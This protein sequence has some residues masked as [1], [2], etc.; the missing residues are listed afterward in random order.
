V[1]RRL[2]LNL[3]LRYDYQRVRESAT[4]RIS[5]LIRTRGIPRTACWE[6]WNSPESISAIRRCSGPQRFCSPR[7][8]RL[9][10][11]RNAERP[12]AAG[13]ASILDD[14]PVIYFAETSPGF[15]GNSTSYVPP[16]GATQLPAFSSSRISFAADP[17][18]GA[19]LGP[20][21]FESQS[22]NFVQSK[23][24]HA[25]LATVDTYGAASVAGWIPARSGYS[26]NK[27]TKLVS[28]AMI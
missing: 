10:R 18:R 15:N 1:T 9:G 5:T 2:T 14:L 11:V 13:Y 23:W 26:G 3:G 21:A 12:F 28:R 22:V 25:V 20:S 6:G 27:G 24:P 8:L 19:S 17:P 4:T 16:G 7:R